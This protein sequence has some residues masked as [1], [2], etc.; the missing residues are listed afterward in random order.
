MQ[1]A[2]DYR[3]KHISCNFRHY[4]VLIVNRVFRLVAVKVCTEVSLTITPVGP[5]QISLFTVSSQYPGG[6]PNEKVGDAR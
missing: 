6:A 3:L 2:S 1:A 5:A 4:R